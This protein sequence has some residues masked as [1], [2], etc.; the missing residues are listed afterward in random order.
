LIP[1]EERASMI[2]LRDTIQSK[3]Y[4]IIR[5]TIIG[6]NV[7][8]FLWQLAQGPYLKRIFDLYGMIPIRY[9]D[10]GVS[11]QFTF[12]QQL[13]PFF[14]YMFLH[15]GF[16]HLLG[17][18]W[19]L[20]IFGDNVEDRLGPSRFLSFYILSGI[21]AVLIHLV[22]N[23]HSRL[24]T[25]GASGAIAGVMGAYF[26]LFPRSRVL[27]MIPIF[28]F[29]FLFEVRAIF[30][31]GYWVIIQFL[32]AS[33]SHGQAGGVA[34]WAHI[35]G[36]IFGL[37]TIRLFL[38]FPRTGISKRVAHSLQRRSTPRLQHI[39][40]AKGEEL[41]IHGTIFITPREA[42]WGARKFVSIPQRRKTVVIT[43]PP[44]MRDGTH[45][46]LRGMGRSSPDGKHGDL[47]LTVKIAR[48]G[49]S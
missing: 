9:S 23:W 2:P 41:D 39:P 16:L 4:P 29:P 42:A 25:I 14:S 12:F 3:T 49:V 34:W 19:F 40:P 27:T 44:E 7:L 18:M 1:L 32:Y 45:L 48:M 13:V 38:A 10:P 31:L 36:F 47:Y 33:M 22:T 5:N 17:N 37:A 30:F 11:G 35:G 24:P 26:L 43:I 28:F 15:G 20:Y 21:T 8:V 46:R 6:I